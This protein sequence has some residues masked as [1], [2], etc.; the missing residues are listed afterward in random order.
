MAGKQLFLSKFLRVAL[1]LSLTGVLFRIKFIA[2]H[3]SLFIAIHLYACRSFSSFLSDL[4]AS[5]YWLFL[6]SDSR[7]MAWVSAAF[8][9]T[10]DILLPT[11]IS[12]RAEA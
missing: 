3:W 8:F 2:V 11:L 7:R 1:C 6:S 12:S 9:F 10:F 5:M 4:K